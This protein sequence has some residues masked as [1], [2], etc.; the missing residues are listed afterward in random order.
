VS[1]GGDGQLGPVGEFPGM[2]KT[3]EPY[4][5]MLISGGYTNTREMRPVKKEV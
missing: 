1:W 5:R 4:C 2:D 3:S